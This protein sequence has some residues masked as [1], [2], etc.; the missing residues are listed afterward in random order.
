MFFRDKYQGASYIKYDG[1]DAIVIV[2]DKGNSRTWRGL[3][4]GSKRV[5][6]YRVD[7]GIVTSKTVSKC[8]YTVW[9]EGEILYLIELKGADYQH[10]LKQIESS[11]D[12]LIINPKIETKSVHGRVVLSRGKI[13]NIR[14]SRET[15]LKVKLKKLHGTLVSKSNLLEEEI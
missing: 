11:L 15:A 14:Y 13:P 12:M 8:D 1:H 4:V 9:V 7:D 6:K 3:N 2:K 10:A 5:I